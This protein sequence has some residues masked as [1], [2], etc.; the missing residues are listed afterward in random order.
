MLKKQLL[1]ALR[2]LGRHKLTTGINLLGLTFGVLACVVIS[3]YV[4]YEFSYDRFH[5]DAGRI[6]RLVTSVRAP[7]LQDENAMAAA[8]VGAALRQ[9]TTAFSAVTTLFTDDTRVLIPVAGKPTRIIPGISSDETYH[10]TFAD[11]DYLK[12]FHYQWLAGN[13]ATALQ[14]PFSVVL[15]ESE[16]RRYFEHG[17]PTDWLGHSVI[18]YDSLTVTVTGI[19]K[20]FKGS[21]PHTWIYL[22]VDDGKGGKVEWACEG[23][24]PGILL[25]AGWT[26]KSL[27]VGDKVT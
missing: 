26:P 12:I 21:N 11:T 7:G 5:P 20:G 15:T 22:T 14:Q 23:R 6:Y 3:L 25:R 4:A 13:P 2:R 16:A 10:I 24:A 1:F 9:R 18:Y 8:P 17:R 19:V 27:T